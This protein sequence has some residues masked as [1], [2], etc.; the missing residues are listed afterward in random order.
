[1]KRLLDVLASCCGLV[2]LA[3]LLGVIAAA[4]RLDSPGPIFFRQE[5][6]GR[7]FKPFSIYKFRTMVVDAPLKGGLL[8]AGE[9]PRITQVGRWLSY[10][11]HSS[12]G[13]DLVTIFLTLAKLL[14]WSDVD[15][16]IRLGA[17]P[18]NPKIRVGEWVSSPM[19][20]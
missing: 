19:N 3:P 14:P 10:V 12:V 18:S 1:M 11:R 16:F 6:M 8:T 2:V 7:G 13:L 4:I 9:D 17:Y 5:R 15:R 20:V